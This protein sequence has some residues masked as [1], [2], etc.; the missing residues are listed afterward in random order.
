[1]PLCGIAVTREGRPVDNPEIEAM[2]CA[3][4]V[5]AGWEGQHSSNAEVGVGATSPIPTTS[6]WKSEQVTVACDADI[7]NR[8][9]I[10]KRVRSLAKDANL[11]HVLAELY[12][13]D[14]SEFLKQL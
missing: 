5:E 4:A 9:V 2:M 3:L 13:Q 10:T 8:D 1:M 12:L 11:A 7:C 14:G 6:I